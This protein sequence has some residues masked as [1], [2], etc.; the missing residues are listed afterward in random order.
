MYR[1]VTFR[2]DPRAATTRNRPISMKA[3]RVH[4]TTHMLRLLA[5]ALVSAAITAHAAPTAHLL[6]A[7]AGAVPDATEKRVHL[8]EAVTL[9]AVFADAGVTLAE[10]PKVSIGGRTVRAKA[11]S[12]GARVRWFKIEP[13]DRS[14]SN[15]DPSFHWHEIGYRESAIDGCADRWSCPADVRT[16]VLGDRGGLGTMAFRVEVS[17]GGRTASSPGLEK[18]HRGGLAP[19]VARVTVRR[20]DTYLGYLTELFNTPYIWGS[21]GSDAVHQAE[22]RIGSDC[23]DFVTYGVRRLG[24]EVPYGSTWSIEKYT[25][26]LATSAGA[27]SDGVFLD[28]AGRPIPIG[29]KGVRPGDLLLFPGHV[30]AFVRDEPPLGVFSASDVMVHTCWAEPTEE[31]LKDT[32]YANGPVK[33]LRWKALDR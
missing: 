8:G 10:A 4:R 33:L 2:D 13:T 27:S 21:A 25:R 18:R 30:G 29:P 9:H 7:R 22:R 3:P 11:P 32:A 5:P 14:L 24:H 28:A 31:P 12:A 23:A 19:D 6:S 1:H 15:T 16:S 26:R 17:L 20:D